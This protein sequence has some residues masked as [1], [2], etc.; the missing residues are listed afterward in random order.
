MTRANSQLAEE[1]DVDDDVDSSVNPP[2]GIPG[3]CILNA[4]L[5]YIYIY[6]L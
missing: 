5:F 2:P 4:I 1:E 3:T 6:I